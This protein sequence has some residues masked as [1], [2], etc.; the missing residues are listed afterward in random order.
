VLILTRRLNEQIV[1]PELE[2]TVRVVAI[3][4]NAVRIG[5]A[6]PQQVRVLRQELLERSPAPAKGARAAALPNC[7]P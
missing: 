5:I 3:Q 1:L 7:H 2:V 6:A 4:G